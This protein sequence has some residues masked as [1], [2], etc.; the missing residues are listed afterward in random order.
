MNVITSA[1]VSLLVVRLDRIGV[2]MQRYIVAQTLTD[3]LPQ[4]DRERW[5]LAG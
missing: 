5:R 2:L 3:V 4:D 1:Q